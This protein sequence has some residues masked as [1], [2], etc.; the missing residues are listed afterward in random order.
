MQLMLLDCQKGSKFST[1][2]LTNCA[3]PANG[4]RLRKIS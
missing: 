2:N 3:M 1:S 4:P